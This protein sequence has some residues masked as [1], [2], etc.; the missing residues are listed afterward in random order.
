MRPQNCI[1]CCLSH[2][3]IVS[4]SRLKKAAVSSSNEYYMLGFIN[5][6]SN[7]AELPEESET[8]C[9]ASRIDISK[10][11]HTCPKPYIH[12]CGAKL[13]MGGLVAWYLPNTPHRQRRKPSFAFF[14]WAGKS[15]LF[16][17]GPVTSTKKEDEDHHKYIVN[18]MLPMV[19]FKKM[20]WIFSEYADLIPY[21]VDNCIK[22]W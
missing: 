8:V 3:I 6:Q 7:V 21:L 13:N 5:L 11:S 9:Q 10:R 1:V 12:R 19:A 4:N 20:Y 14:I 2:S 15:C 18:V 22:T 16:A 17:G